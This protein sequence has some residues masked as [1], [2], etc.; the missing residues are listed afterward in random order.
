MDIIVKKILS[1]IYGNRRGWCFTPKNFLDLGIRPTIDSALSRLTEKGTIRRLARGLYDYPQKHSQ[2]GLL[3]PQ[4]IAIAK[5]IA[6]RDAS[7]FQP[8]GAYAAHILGLTD[9]VPAQIVFLTDGKD[10]RIVIGKQEIWLK[11]TT[12]RNMSTAGQI[13]GSVFYA[14]RHLG[15]NEINDTHVNHLRKAL[16]ASDKKR[17]LLDKAIAPIWMHI[18]IERIA[19]ENNGAQEDI[20]PK[21][22]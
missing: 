2:I 21:K 13:S 1:R 12:P 11:N 14:F 8:S 5:A 4:P 20:F 6:S 16:S 18:F 9:Q 3:S 19:K 17:I 7:R 22:D 15:K 10:R